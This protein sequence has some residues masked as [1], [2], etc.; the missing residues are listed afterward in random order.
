M[1]AEIAITK[2]DNI[3]KDG[4]IQNLIAQANSRYILLNT[5]ENSDNFPP[6]TISDESLNL[7]GFYYLNL[8]CSIA[9]DNNLESA[10]SP[11]EKGASILEYTNNYLASKMFVSNYYGLISALAYYVCFQYSKSYILTKK[12]NSET[13]ISKLL[14]L[15]LRRDYYNLTIE[16]DKLMV[17]E[18]YS[19]DYLASNTDNLESDTKVYE[20]IIAKALDRLVDYAYN[21][22]VESIM[23]AKELL[24]ALKEIAEV[25]NDPGIW[26]IVRL[27]LLISDSFKEASLWNT[28]GIFFDIQNNIVKKYI[29]SL[30]NLQPNGVFELFITQRK[31]LNKVI[32]SDGI[33]CVISIPTSSG[34]TR[35]AELAILNSLTNFPD[36]KILYIAPFVSLAF[37]VETSLGNIFRNLNFTT[38][39]LY[40]GNFYSK[41]DE[42]VI[43]ESHIIIATPEKSK[44]IL[45]GNNDILNQIKLIIVDEGHLLGPDKRLIIN[46]IF[47]EELRYSLSKNNGKFLLLSAVLPN[48]EEL[49]EWL[50][51][52][53]GN[54]YKDKWRPSD[55]RLGTL[56][57]TGSAVNIYW[58][59]NDSERESFNK[60][61]IIK[62]K[63]SFSRK[64][65]PKDKNEA[66]TATAFKLKSFGKVLIFVGLK[67][68]VFKLAE[69]YNNCIGIGAPNHVWKNSQ[70]WK[71]FELSC[72][73]AYGN[74][75]DN[76]WL[77]YARKG[78]LCHNADLHSDVRLPL[79]R[80]MRLD[81]PLVI[82]STST[83]GQGVNLGVSSVIFSTLS[84]S[85]SP[86]THRDFWNIAGRAGRAFVDHE[87]KILVAID[88]SK[89][90]T[91]REKYRNKYKRE[92][93]QKYFNKEKIDKAESGILFLLNAL[94]NIAN[95]QGVSFELLIQLITENKLKEIDE[96]ANIIEET[97]DWIDDALLSLHLI[98]NNESEEELYDYSWIEEYFRGSLAYIQASR[99]PSLD[100]EDVLKFLKARVEGI[101]KKVGNSKFRWKS[102]IDSGLPLSSDLLIEKMLPQIIEGI[103]KFYEEGWTTENLIKLLKNV[104]E[105]VKD[106]PII[107]EEGDEILSDNI[108]LIRTYWL[109][110]IS[111]NQ[112][113]LLHNAR[114]I[115]KGLYT[116][117]LPWILNGI[118]KKLRLRDLETEAEV[119]EE[120]SILTEAGLP[121]LKS[122]KIYQ[123]GIRS[124]TA[125]VEIG[126]YFEDEI[127]KKSIREYKIAII[128]NEGG[129]VEKISPSTM[130]WIKILIA[131]NGKQGNEIKKISDFTFGKVHEKTE[132]L[133]ARR[134]NN[135]QYLV[136][137][138]KSFIKEIIKSDIDFKSVSNFSGIYFKYNQETK[139]WQMQKDNPYI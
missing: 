75:D 76:L 87:G 25:K 49:A 74:T 1:K 20:L 29:N 101:V 12:L 57:W 42:K 15:F 137:P 8:G 63:Q 106:I 121:D 124:R 99:H 108:D 95:N 46:E 6:Y 132:I 21:G 92:E 93:V 73:E 90:A 120:L 98:N 28:L 38:S 135:K 105:L 67:K 83:L 66:I 85:G 48:A 2:L 72:I 14:Y 7:L 45:R 89:N 123:A 86:L 44:A 127:W 100:G 62:E 70:D 94:K 35:I 112:I 39:Q 60:S 59:N 111:L 82:I 133:L 32:D 47:Y 31:S 109:K 113:L 11:L 102:L 125:A 52:K 5:S 56:E 3:E 16:I 107:R 115:I 78:I 24:K 114:S 79:E 131:Q 77:K 116:Y 40:G 80:L 34:K 96:E 53:D 23:A 13:V 9:E 58:K 27:L 134:I 139:F 55:E 104:E 26:W 65:Y 41:L 122:V 43:Q 33:G 50:T 22:Q 64:I 37:E 10:L 17:D 97:L 69:A 19:D 71:I 136:S 110:G 117:K 4:L 91:K 128:L 51:T 30:T 129:I 81:N 36:C 61:F 18:S 130:E 126:K 54:V 68:S 88:V 103:N 118:A 84:Q 138:D 119:L